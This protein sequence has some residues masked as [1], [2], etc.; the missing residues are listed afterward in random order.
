MEVIVY[1][2]N[3]Q[4]PLNTIT[5]QTETAPSAVR[6]WNCKSAVGFSHWEKPDRADS[7][8]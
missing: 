2:H 7:R 6:V 5:N 3:D 8:A 4:N 1:F